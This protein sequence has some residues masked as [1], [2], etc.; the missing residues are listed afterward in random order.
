M[1]VTIEPYNPEW[2][3]KFRDKRDQLL[4]IL[5]D[6]SITSI[7]HVGST[8]IPSLMAKPVIDIDIIIPASSLEAARNALKN[9][10]YDD[11]GELN[12]PGRFVFRQPGYGKLDAAHG[13]DKDGEVRYNTYLMVEGYPSLKNHLDTK[14]VLM[15]NQELREEYGRVKRML[16]DTELE[17]LDHYTFAKTEIMCKILRSAGWSEEDLAPLIEANT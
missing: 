11:L 4:D 7:E 8:S 6:V 15:E 5:Q 17:S 3:L 16:R 10:G 12:I 14:R 1:R 2:P 9:A 13:K